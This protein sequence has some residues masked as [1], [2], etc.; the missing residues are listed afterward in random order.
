MAQRDDG[1]LQEDVRLLGRVLGETIA[2]LRGP[3][4][5]E[6]VEGMRRAALSLRSGALPGGRAAF[7]ERLTAL[8]TEDLSLLA[9][10]FTAFFH[11]VNAAEEIERLRALR[12]RDQDGARPVEGSVAAAI[13]EVSA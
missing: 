4:A 12:A 3:R 2:E 6:L 9:E 1:R 8:P 7:A 10:S 11:L 5:L 13:A